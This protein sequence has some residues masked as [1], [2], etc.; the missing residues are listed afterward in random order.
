MGWIT[1]YCV[2]GIF[3]FSCDLGRV[4]SGDRWGP[5]GLG[6]EFETYSCRKD[7]ACNFSLRGV[8]LIIDNE[9]R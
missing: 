1:G 3:P 7:D 6:M 4:Y 2:V 8:G 9:G 5:G